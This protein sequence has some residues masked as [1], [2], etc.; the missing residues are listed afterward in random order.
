MKS[1]K[2]EERIKKQ[3]QKREIQPSAEAWE[4]LEVRLE[5]GGRPKQAQIWWLGVAAAIA[6]VFFFL[7]TFFKSPT[8]PAVVEQNTEQVI[9]AESVLQSRKENR[10]V[11]EE[12]E[13]EEISAPE[14]LSENVEIRKTEKRVA[15]QE[16][17]MEKPVLES[18]EPELVPAPQKEDAV[19]AV[20]PG[21]TTVTDAEVD[22]LLNSAMAELD[23]SQAVSGVQLVD[24]EDLLDE[25]EYELEL[26]FRQK[27]FEVLK[28]GLSKAKTAVANRNY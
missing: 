18:G 23:Q 27:V 24:A 13:K 19:A 22:A 6:G 25:V 16:A 14:P 9:P 12:T 5:Q 7:G 17:L 28:E 1:V 21:K 4:K 3:L 2:F 8:E 11:S 10:I 15:V 20:S 26:N